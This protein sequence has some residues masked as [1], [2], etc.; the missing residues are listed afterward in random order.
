MTAVISG[1]AVF[2]NASAVREFGDATL[3]TMLKNGVAAIILTGIL[4]ASRPA[5][6]A[7]RELSRRQWAQLLGIGLVGGG[8]A[9]LLFFNGLALASAPSAAVIHKT[10]FLWVA[11][12]AVPL[13]SERIGWLQVA[14]LAVLAGSQI[15]IAPM[16]GVT[17]GIGETLIALATVLW[18]MEV[19]VARRLL[20]GVPSSVG[21]AGRMVIGM[22][23]LVPA[24]VLTGR[25]DALSALTATQLLWVVVTGVLLTG[26]VATWYAA[27]QRAPAT[28]VTAVLV[29]AAPVTAALAAVRDGVVPLDL[30]A[31]GYLLAAVGATAIAW[32]SLRAQRAPLP[33]TR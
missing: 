20:Q 4:L 10:L 2:V 8:L 11:L 9:F 3:F 18:A 7:A 16:S 15:L 30:P 13:L 23:V 5:R 24:V 27:L 31:A 22:A 29:L 14:A 28:V 6:H 1:I 12:M 25:V 17:W 21:A 33:A 26:Y 32:A 19:I